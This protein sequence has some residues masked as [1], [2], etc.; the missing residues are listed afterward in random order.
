MDT[1]RLSRRMMKGHKMQLF[2]LQLSF[3]GWIL[4]NMLTFGVG[5]LWLIP[6]VMTTFAAFYQD[7]K[8]EY[9]MKEAQQE[10]AL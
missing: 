7:V 2:K 10:S 4:I 6:Y 9:F 1:L 5:S 8:A 3:I